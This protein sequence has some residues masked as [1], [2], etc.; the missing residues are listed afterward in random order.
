MAENKIKDEYSLNIFMGISGQEDMIF[1]TLNQRCPA[2]LLQDMKEK[3]GKERKPR[4]AVDHKRIYVQQKG[5]QWE[6]W[7]YLLMFW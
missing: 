6:V 2:V 1:V 5:D 7:L 4:G 3:E